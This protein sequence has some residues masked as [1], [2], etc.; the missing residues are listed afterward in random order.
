MTREVI[1]GCIVEERPCKKCTHILHIPSCDPSH[2][3]LE[4][5]VPSVKTI[6]GILWVHIDI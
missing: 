3:Q 6:W 4:P 1:Q 5:W 2:R